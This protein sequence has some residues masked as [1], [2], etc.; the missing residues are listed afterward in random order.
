[1]TLSIYL[2]DV[3]TL[4]NTAN[5]IFPEEIEQF[6]KDYVKNVQLL[7]YPIKNMVRKL[8]S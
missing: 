3:L 5:K 2:V 6:V 4:L 1:M 7:E 8:R